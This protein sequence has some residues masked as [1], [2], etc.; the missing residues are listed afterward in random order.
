MEGLLLDVIVVTSTLLSGYW[1]GV[2]ILKLDRHLAL[3]ISSGSAICGA[4][5]VLA[6]EDVLKSE[7][8]KASV[9]VG[10]VVLFGTLGMF[11]YPL[12]QHAGYLISRIISLVFLP[13]PACKSR[14]SAGGR[15]QCECGGRQYRGDSED[16]ASTIISAVITGTVCL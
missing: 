4:A 10:T 1:L 13:A 6:V 3:L 14:A 9:A 5:A 16:D 7:S 2:K 12:L 11:L 8:Y 15:R